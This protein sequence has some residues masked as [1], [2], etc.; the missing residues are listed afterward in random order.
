MP[1][2]NFMVAVYLGVVV[3]TSARDTSSVVMAPSA[4][5]TSLPMDSDLVPV[6]TRRTSSPSAFSTVWEGTTV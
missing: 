5:M 1:S 3:S 6:W 4:V 2:M